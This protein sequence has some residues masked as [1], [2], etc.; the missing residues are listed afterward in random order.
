MQNCHNV[1]YVRELYLTADVIVDTEDTE[2]AEFVDD[3]LLGWRDHLLVVVDE[4]TQPAAD[5]H[6]AQEQQTQQ[7]LGHLQSACSIFQFQ[8]M[9]VLFSCGS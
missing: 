9:Y 2:E 8:Y 4:E 3:V 6:G 5:Q 7:D 1:F